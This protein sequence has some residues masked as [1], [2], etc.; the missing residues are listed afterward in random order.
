[1][2]VSNLISTRMK[3]RKNSDRRAAHVKK[4][5]SLTLEEKV[6]VIKRYEHNER[7]VDIVSHRNLRIDV[8]NS[9]ESS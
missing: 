3:K 5:K 9:K 7:T 1:M 8:K 2:C 4:R 6:D